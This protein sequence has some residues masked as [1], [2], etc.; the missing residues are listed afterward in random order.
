MLPNLLTGLRIALIPIVM[1]LMLSGDS[2]YREDLAVLF[3]GL[4]G[5]T[6]FFDGYLARKWNKESEIGR[7]SD[8]IADKLI[9]VGVLVILLVTGKIMLID[10]LPVSL[11]L[12]REIFV[13]GL[14]EYLGNFSVKLPVS[15]LAKW[16]TAVQ[17]IALPFL[18]FFP[19][20]S[21]YFII[22]R[23]LLWI[24]AILAIKTG[25]S[26]FKVAIK[27]MKRS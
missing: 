13:S 11:I 12:F 5:I 27:Y 9:V 18:I 17:L 4:A 8:P 19:I 26:Y 1:L 25:W 20:W 22:G 21:D 23:V 2:F 7:F 24:S 15:W 10:L 16:K 14:R 3:F 6:D